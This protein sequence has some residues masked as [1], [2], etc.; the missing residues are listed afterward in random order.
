MRNNGLRNSGASA[1]AGSFEWKKDRNWKDNDRHLDFNLPD[2]LSFQYVSD[3][4]DGLI[5]L[6][7]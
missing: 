1:P 4:V 2:L 3:L 5:T 7:D 6:T